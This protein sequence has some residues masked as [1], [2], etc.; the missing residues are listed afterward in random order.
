VP[1]A[2]N[3][4][5]LNRYA[6]TF[7][8]PLKYTDP[9]GYCAVGEYADESICVRQNARGQN[10][11][12]NGGGLGRIERAV[13]NFLLTEDHSYLNSIPDNVPFGNQIIETVSAHLYGGEP[14]LGD[15]ISAA[16][17]AIAT[18]PVAVER[19][20]HGV[21]GIIGSFFRRGSSP[22]ITSK[23]TL[24]Y[25][26]SKGTQLAKKAHQAGGLTLS[27]FKNPHGKDFAKYS[28]E[29]LDRAAAAGARVNFDLSDVD[30]DGALSVTGPHAHSVTSQ[31]LRYIRDNWQRFQKI[32]TFEKEG[33]VISPPW[34]K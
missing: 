33:Q 20:I 2:G 18:N 34:I 21:V 7:N 24:F 5:S 15:Y 25:G 14:S 9:S 16:G 8:N 29:I 13:A 11:I 31:E 22:P 4:Q 1:G 19:G 27:D 6:Y 10:V 32:V 30:V 23:T 28:K 17:P 12:V 3:P 26:L